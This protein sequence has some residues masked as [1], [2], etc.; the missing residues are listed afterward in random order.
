MSIANNI[1][2]LIGNT[3]LLH[4]TK[5]NPGPGRLYAKLEMFNP[6]SI[7]DRAAKNMLDEAEKTGQLKPGGLIVEPTSGNTGIALAFLAAVRGYTITLTMPE[8]MSPERIKLLKALGAQI[9]LTPAQKGMK[10]A[11]E[12]AQKII[13]QTPGAFMPAQFDNPANAQAH[14]QTAQEILADLDGKVDIFISAVGTGGTLTGT[15]EELKKHCPHLHTVAVEPADSPVLSGGEAG[16][17]KL[18]GIGAGFIPKILNTKLIDEIIPV[19]AQNAGKTAR[20]LAKKEGV[21]AGISAGAALWA[22]LQVAARAENKDKNIVVIFPD[23]GER[24]L[25]TWE[26][27][28]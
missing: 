19:T 25:S 3:P 24:Y 28:E 6:Y 2:E 7:K 5:L 16:P 14:R 11:I 23:T 8:N 18:Q 9:I 26:F 22:A 20:A 12:E 21:L 17:H 13:S 4:I 10:G 15:A 27:E 1:A